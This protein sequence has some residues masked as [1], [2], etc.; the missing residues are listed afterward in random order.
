MK[1]ER[2]RFRRL[3]RLGKVRAIAR[4]EAAREAAR[5]EGTL[6]QLEA[7]A[8]RTHRLTE[9]YRGRCGETDGLAL[10]QLQHFASGLGTVAAA[11]TADV[12]QARAVADRLQHGLA[13]AERRSA[14][15]EDRVRAHAQALNGQQEPQSH[16]ARQPLGTALE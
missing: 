9:D 10:R 7:L 4:Q 14:A 16:G 12:T 3:Q 13:L 15:V 6:A 2:A 1:A 5:A 8:E 11:T